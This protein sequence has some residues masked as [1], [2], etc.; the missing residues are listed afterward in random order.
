MYYSLP[1]DEKATYVSFMTWRQKAL[2][3]TTFMQSSCKKGWIIHETRRLMLH[4]F[5]PILLTNIFQIN[6]GGTD[7]KY[8]KPILAAILVCCPPPPPL[9]TN[10]PIFSRRK[11]P[12]GCYR[13][14]LE[15]W[16]LKTTTVSKFCLHVFLCKYFPCHMP[17]NF[18]KLDVLQF[19]LRCSWGKSDVDLKCTT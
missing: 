19:G 2:T 15:F 18:N 17:I 3:L 6:T 16:E 7:E 1:I 14:L 13:N 5:T 8:L 10:K 12:H 9:T 4:I 11:C